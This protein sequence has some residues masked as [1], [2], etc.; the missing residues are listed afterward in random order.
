M[1]RRRWSASNRIAESDHE[2]SD[3][4]DDSSASK[5]DS[6]RLDN[7][8]PVNPRLEKMNSLKVNNTSESLVKEFCVEILEDLINLI[9]ETQEDTRTGSIATDIVDNKTIMSSLKTLRKK[10]FIKEQVDD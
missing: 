10:P 7:L 2:E 1:N 3:E 9:S 8:S 5:G 6:K 4:D